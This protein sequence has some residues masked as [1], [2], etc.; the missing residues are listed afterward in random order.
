VMVCSEV[1]GTR[2]VEVVVV[3]STGESSVTGARTGG[4]DCTSA[5]V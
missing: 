4:G 5:M 3:G 1:D 2:S